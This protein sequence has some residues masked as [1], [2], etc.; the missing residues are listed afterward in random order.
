MIG[1]RTASQLVPLFNLPITSRSRL[2]EIES[3]RGALAFQVFHICHQRLEQLMHG[4]GTTQFDSLC[5]AMSMWEEGEQGGKKKRKER[6]KKKTRDRSLPTTICGLSGFTLQSGSVSELHFFPCI[7]V[8]PA[9][10]DHE[11][12]KMWVVRH[13]LC[14]VSVCMLCAGRLHLVHGAVAAEPDVSPHPGI[15]RIKAARAASGGACS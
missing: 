6:E 15:W 9:A 12:S 5:P 1:Q 10:A 13:T 2:G 4:Q 7:Q 8:R 3:L 14:Y 11:G